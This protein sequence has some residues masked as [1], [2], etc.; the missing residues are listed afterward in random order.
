MPEVRKE[1]LWSACVFQEVPRKEDGEDAHEVYVQLIHNHGVVQKSLGRTVTK[2]I[3]KEDAAVPLDLMGEKDG[4]RASPGE[5]DVRTIF[6][7]LHVEVIRVFQS[8]F[9]YFNGQY[10]IFSLR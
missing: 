3:V 5:Y 9:K 6:M 7:K 2:D 4:P 1:L 10:V 8:I